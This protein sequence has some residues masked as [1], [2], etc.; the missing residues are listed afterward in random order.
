MRTRLVIFLLAA[1]VTL[2]F[3]GAAGASVS[4]KKAPVK[5]SGGAANKG[6]ATVKNNA[7]DLEADDFYFKKTFLK[8]TA[9]ATV[10]VTIE[11]EG[12]TQHTFTIDSLDIDEVVD[13]GDSATVQVQIPTDG[14][15]LVFYCTLHGAPGKM[16]GAFFVKPASTTSTSSG[17]TTSTSIDDGDDSGGN[18]GP[19]GG[20]GGYG[21]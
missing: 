4:S 10:E 9:G 14:T 7:V 19:G 5:V 17:D 16:K 21:Y 8:T 2:G 12:S 3:I 13:P 20:S 11:N 15:P 18:S 6:T 1:M